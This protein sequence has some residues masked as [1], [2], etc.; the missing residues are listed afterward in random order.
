MPK[1]S[2][3]IATAEGSKKLGINNL[4]KQGYIKK[5][6]KEINILSWSNN[7]GDK[8]GIISLE[9]CFSDVE[10]WIRLIYTSSDHYTGNKYDV[11]YKVKIIG[12]P[13]NLGKGFNYYFICPFSYRKCKI[14]YSAYGSHY[15]K[16]RYAYTYPIYYNCQVCS[17]RDYTN[18]RYWDC[19]NKLDK[20]I[21][22][23]FR[24]SYKGSKTRSLERIEILANRVKYFDSLRWS[25][26]D[27]FMKSK[28]YF[29]K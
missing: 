12:I 3:G 20:L 21:E 15:F 8:T 13:S 7:F 28:G 9:S 2:Q 14:L 10:K 11:D 19:K 18:T 17:K 27:S 16:S 25:I 1:P 29:N 26:L 6:C 5:N 23:N 4:L 22:S 24:E